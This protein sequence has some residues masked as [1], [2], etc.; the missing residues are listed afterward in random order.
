[1][2]DLALLSF[3]FY[4]LLKLFGVKIMSVRRYA[5]SKQQRKD[6][7]SFGYPRLSPASNLEHNHTPL[8]HIQ[9]RQKIVFG[10]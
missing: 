2:V 8:N 3:M 4:M 5:G 1:M 6:P 7:A 9:V 10:P